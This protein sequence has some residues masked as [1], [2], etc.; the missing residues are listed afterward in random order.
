MKNPILLN[1]AMNVVLALV[2][3]FLNTWALQN[4]LEETF[5]ALALLYGLVIIFANAS[6][7][8]LIA[9]NRA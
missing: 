7:L 2:M 6:F 5:V 3:L 8:W 9:R 1:V 4:Q